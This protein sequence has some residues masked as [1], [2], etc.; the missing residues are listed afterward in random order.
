MPGLVQKVLQIA[1]QQP[2]LDFMRIRASFLD[3]RNALIEHSLVPFLDELVY[4][5]LGVVGE[6]SVNRVDAVL[7]EDLSCHWIGGH[8]GEAR[9]F[10]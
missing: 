8:V 9:G 3:F 2:L 4:E 1:P 5:L 6:K 10:L 7:F